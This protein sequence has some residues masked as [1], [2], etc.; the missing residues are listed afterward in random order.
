MDFHYIDYI[1]NFT[2]IINYFK[3]IHHISGSRNDEKDIG[4]YHIAKKP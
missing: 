3:Y 4:T 2:V 1:D